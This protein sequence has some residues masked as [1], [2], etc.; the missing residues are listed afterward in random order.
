MLAEAAVNRHMKIKQK[1]RGKQPFNK[2]HGVVITGYKKVRGANVFERLYNYAKVLRAKIEQ[3]S[4]DLTMMGFK[5]VDLG[6]SEV[7][8]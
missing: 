7:Y 4:R 3:R 1:V 6:N 5:G 8:A 2:L